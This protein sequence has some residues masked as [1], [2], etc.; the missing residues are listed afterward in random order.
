[1]GS[2]GSRDIP[3]RKPFL[4][5][6]LQRLFL[7]LAFAGITVSAFGGDA[8]LRVELAWGTDGTRPDGKDL[9]E[10]DSKAREKLRHL[11]WKNYWVVKSETP[12]VPE[13][14]S[15]S[16]VLDRC[17]VDLKVLPNNQIE[18][19]LSTVLPDRELKLIK[20]VQ[21]SMDALKHGEFLIIAGDDKKKWDDAWFVIIRSE[22]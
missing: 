13:K 16:L 17:Q 19:R 11:R 4:M 9:V 8:K 7:L 2:F 6:H 3:I 10:L 22:P 15:R 5:N 18:V 12:S 1:M 14:S 21:H 20:T